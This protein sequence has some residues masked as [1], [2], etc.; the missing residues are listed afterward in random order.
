[1]KKLTT[2]LFTLLICATAMCQVPVMTM[3]TAKA[4]GSKFSFELKT[5]AANT[6]IQVDF[7]DGN[8]ISET[9]STTGK[10]ISGTLVGSQT[11]KVYGKGITHFD[12]SN[13]ALTALDVSQNTT[14]A[15]LNCFRN[16]LTSLDLSQ[17]IALT[18]LNCS[19]NQL[20]TLDAP[21][22]GNLIEI[23]CSENQLTALNITKNTEL[24]YLSCTSNQLTAIDV[25]NNVKLTT[26]YCSENQLTSLDVTKN[27]E[28]LYL[29]CDYNQITAL[30]VTK[31]TKFIYFYCYGNQ[32]T[33]LDVTKNIVLEGLSC[34]N[35]KLTSLDVTKNTELTY[36]DC[37]S[38]QL[39]TLDLTQNAG[40]THLY[41][42]KNPLNVLEVTKNINLI[43]LDCSDNQLASLNISQ[44]TL[45]TRLQCSS[46]QLTALDISKNTLLTKLYC[47]SNYIKALDVI[48]DTALIELNCLRNQLTFV[49]LPFK[50]TNW[51]NYVYSSQRP[52]SIVKSRRIGGELDLSSQI[53]INGI[54]TT[55]TWDTKGGP[56]LVEGTDYTIHDGKTIF[57][58]VP[59]DSVYCAMKNA[60]FPDLILT[61][62]YT[63]ITS[64]TA[65]SNLD[66]SEIEMYSSKRTLYINIPYNAQ[67]SI[68]DPNGRLVFSKE[69]TTGSNSIQIQNAGLYLVNFKGNNGR[70]T[71]KVF[72]N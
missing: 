24:E 26:F 27:T 70:F 9:V 67:A 29:Y 61:T 7:G 6:A 56:S 14:L 44:N 18:E 39:T 49:S 71:K 54:P 36:L 17:N 46:N 48:Q 60:T 12:C 51:E 31:N 8:L 47:H 19:S 23:V 72:V 40:L 57:L 68:Y 5:N 16:Q 3:T 65:V 21:I 55:Y 10:T 62:T 34:R 41:C 42:Y 52:I 20:T 11:V 4:I 15:E 64:T 38:N 69:L 66:V 2:I 32:L 13:K 63:K 37:S 53:S 58:K 50:Q 30:D 25:S 59:A 43:D 28:L 33:A 22:N 45:L 1:M 35:N